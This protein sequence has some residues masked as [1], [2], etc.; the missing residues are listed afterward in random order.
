MACSY[1]FRP[2]ID[3]TH[4]I[5]ML[6]FLLY[7]VYILIRADTIDIKANEVADKIKQ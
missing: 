6:L 3:S 2:T 5:T 7:I 4:W 1:E